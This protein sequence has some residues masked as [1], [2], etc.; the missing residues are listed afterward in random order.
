MYKILKTLLK[1]PKRILK[2]TLFEILWFS[3]V[4]LGLFFIWKW[5]HSENQRNKFPDYPVIVWW[6]SGFPGTSRTIECE[7]EIKCDVFSDVNNNEINDVEAYLFYASN[8]HFDNLPL[9]RKPEIIW[10]L[11]HEES[12]RNVEELMHEVTLSLFNYSAT[13]SRYSD[14][15]FPLQHLESLNDITSTN[16]FVP[17]K[18]KNDLLHD[19]SSVLYLQSDCETASERDAYVKE[20]MKLIDVD[21]Y[22]VC[23]KNKEMPVEFVDDYLNNLND[24]NFLRYIARYKFVIAIE[25]GVCDDYVTEKFWRAIKVGSIPIYFGS[26][27]AKD[28]TPN[29]KSAIFLEDYPTTKLMSEYINKLNKND[30]LYEEYLDHKIKGKISNEKLINEFNNKPYQRDALEIAGKFECLVCE[31]IYDHR[32]GMK[33]IRIVNKKHYDC[34]EPISALTMQVNPSND[35]VYSWNAAKT[36]AEDIYKEIVGN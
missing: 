11:Y 2:L 17:T 4:C 13:F 21:S 26:P 14:I 27:S 23:L 8:L 29:N 19:I 3:V 31:K 15:P 1:L 30:N 25:N 5:N 20:L 18:I 12:P 22:G 28:W 6:T 9:P 35:W 16:Y 33:K 36:R 7:R 24:E 34:P 10:G 32:K